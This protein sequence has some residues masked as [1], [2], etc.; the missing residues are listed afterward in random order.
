MKIYLRRT[1]ADGHIIYCSY[2]E[3]TKTDDM[4]CYRKVENMLKDKPISYL[5][6]RAVILGYE[7]R[8]FEVPDNCDHAVLFKNEITLL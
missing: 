1:Q 3:S 6:M 2:Y 4:L 8:I 5:R 7:L